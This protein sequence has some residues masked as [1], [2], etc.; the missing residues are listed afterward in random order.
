MNKGQQKNMRNSN[1][2]CSL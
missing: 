1:W 2:Y